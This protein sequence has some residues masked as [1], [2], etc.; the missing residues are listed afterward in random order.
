M[1][2]YIKKQKGFYGILIKSAF[3][4]VF[5]FVVALIFIGDIFL[6]LAQPFVSLVTSAWHFLSKTRITVPDI[7]IPQIKKGVKVKEV[8]PSS[9]FEE[10]RL[11]VTY[12]SV[13][14]LV[15]LSLVFIARGYEFIL[16]LPNPRLIGNINFPVSTQIFDRNGNLLYDVYHDQNRTPIDIDNVPDHVIQATIAIEDKDFYSHNGISP[17]GG[18]LRAIKEM[19][20][21]GQLQGGSTITQQL[22]KSSLLTPERTLERKVREAVLALWAEQI[23]SKKEILEM[24]LNQVPYGGSSYGIEEAAQTYFNK[25]AHELTVGEAALLAGLTRAPSKYS[26]FINPELAIRRR[27]EVLHAMYELGYVSRDQY[28]SEIQA[29]V[30]IQPPKVFVRAPHFVFYVKALLEE[31]Y[32]IRRVEEGGLRVMTTLDLSIQEESEKIL[33][34]ELEKIKGLNVSNGAALVT[35]PSTGEVLAMVG[36]KNYYEQPY[37]AFNVTTARRQPGSS[38]KPL[39]YSLALENSYTAATII[40]DSP[41]QFDIAGSQPYRP[42]NYDGRYHGKVPLRYALANSYN[43]PAVKTLNTLG[44]SNFI[45]HAQKLGITTWDTPERYGLSLAL[46]GAEVKMT[47]MAVAYGTFANSG[48]RV[49]LNPILSITDYRNQQLLARSGGGRQQVLSEETA[50]ILSNIMSDNFARQFAFGPNSD[51]NMPGYTVA[52]KTGTTNSKRDNWTF[53]FN[54]KFLTAVW[55]GNNDNSPMNPRLTSGITGAS[56]IWH[57]IMLNVLEKNIAL[58]G[59]T[60]PNFDFTIPA[61]VVSKPCYFGKVEYFK[62]GTEKS[63]SCRDRLMNQGVTPTPMLP[64]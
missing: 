19:I 34:E 60:Q 44:V 23:F 2:A 32:G 11:K 6:S 10:A 5:Y 42:V 64:Q 52:A 9:F 16:D 8:A 62:T 12:F 47:D 33:S 63:V 46:G 29:M 31:Q 26:P 37:G 50:F 21:T 54:R 35:S 25:P 58:K 55:V 39:L 61:G 22:V 56:P 36:S 59:D 43:I 45:D 30:S 18:I 20:V 53:G 4:V 15:A 49:P 40:D 17:I 48:M 51:L 13:G 27:N 28:N 14:V 3:S 57:R 38:I 7:K 41:V 24:Y 1:P